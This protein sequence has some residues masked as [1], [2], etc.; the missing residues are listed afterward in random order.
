PGAIEH[1]AVAE[2]VREWP[3][4]LLAPVDRNGVIDLEALEALLADGPPALV[5]LM[6]ANNETGAIQP[7]AAAAR[8]VHAAQGV[9]LV[10]AAQALGR[11]EIDMIRLGAD[12]LAVS[13]VKAGGPPGAGAL[14][15]T[16]GFPFAPPRAGGGQERGARPGTENVPAISG[17]GA[18]CAAAVADLGAQAHAVRALRDRFEAG[19]ARIAPDAVIFAQDV[20]RLP[21]TTLAAFPGR[22]AEAAL[23]SLDLAGVAASSGAA[24]SS[25]KVRASRV[26]AAM[27]VPAALSQCALRFSFG[28]ASTDADIDAALSALAR[29]CAP[30][31][32]GA[33]S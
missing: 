6:L 33:V 30:R 7:V 4:A 29:I 8:L 14:V 2:A 3:D 11:I 1:D 10:D 22:R 5:A 17:F 21:N 20:A 13:S 18:A 24:C 23:I 32:E 15:L 26:L 9:L 27:G 19:L 12:A 28:W 16:P 31:L 25:G